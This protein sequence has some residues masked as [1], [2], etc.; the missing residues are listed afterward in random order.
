MNHCNLEND[1]KLFKFMCVCVF[2]FRA[3]CDFMMKLETPTFSEFT[4]EQME[5]GD[6]LLDFL[7]FDWLKPK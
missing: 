2:L 6:T 3:I 4:E 7:D 5:K 1:C